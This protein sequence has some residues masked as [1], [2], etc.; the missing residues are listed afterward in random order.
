MIWRS[1]PGGCLHIDMVGRWPTRE[2]VLEARSILSA[3]GLRTGELR[4]LLDF[5]RLEPTPLPSIEEL[6]R[7]TKEWVED[8]GAPA[9]LAFVTTQSIDAAAQAFLAAARRSRIESM[10]QSFTD[11]HRAIE[12][13]TVAG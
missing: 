9:K 2:E 12:W 7:Y 4:V 13:L 5:R 3:A 10:I 11:E 6:A 8:L 1:I